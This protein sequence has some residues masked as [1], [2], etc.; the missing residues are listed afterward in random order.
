M[1]R[2]KCSGIRRSYLDTR[3]E[4]GETCSGCLRWSAATTPSSVL[5]TEATVRQSW[6]GIL[7]HLLAIEM[8]LPF[9]QR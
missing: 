1:V 7:A 8:A 4:R 3:F 5:M 6:I 9:L 2:Q